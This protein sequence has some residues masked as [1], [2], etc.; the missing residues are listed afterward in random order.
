M[1]GA[2][3][4]V[5]DP[6]HLRVRYIGRKISIRRNLNLNRILRVQA[7]IPNTTASEVKLVPEE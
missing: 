6:G 1:I 4:K 2:L 3:V 5:L 7:A